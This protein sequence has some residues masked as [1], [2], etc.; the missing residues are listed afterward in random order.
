[1]TEQKI[2]DE[3]RTVAADA[4]LVRIAIFNCGDYVVEAKQPASPLTLQW[5]A[6]GTRVFPT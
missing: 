5:W 1:M 2:L 4:V 6:Y 3:N